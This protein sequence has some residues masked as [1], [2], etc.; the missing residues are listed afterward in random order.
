MVM[1]LAIPMD[2]R[3]LGLADLRFK[4][5][6]NQS[7]GAELGWMLFPERPAVELWPTSGNVSPSASVP[8]P[9][10]VQALSLPGYVSI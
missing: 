5:I 4:M 6:I 1:S 10:L 8:P 2:V 3:P 7:D 9:A